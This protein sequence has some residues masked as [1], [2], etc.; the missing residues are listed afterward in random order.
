MNDTMQ[1]HNRATNGNKVAYIILGINISPVFDKI[2]DNRQVIIIGSLMHGRPAI[3]Q[4]QYQHHP[5]QQAVA[6]A[7]A[8]AEGQHRG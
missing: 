6:A 5:T 7:A 3:L 2:L 4:K 8:A 1:E